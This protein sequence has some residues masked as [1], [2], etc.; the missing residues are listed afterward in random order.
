MQVVLFDNNQRSKLAPLTLTRAVGMIRMGVFTN[1]ERWE[2]ISGNEVHIYTLP[3]LQ[4]LYPKYTGTDA[5][6]IDAAILPTKDFIEQVKELK[7]EEA[8]M[9][10]HQ[11]IIACRSGISYNNF[12]EEELYNVHS[13]KIVMGLKE[14]EYPWQIMQWNKQAIELDIELIKEK[15][16]AK[17]SIPETVTTINRD[18]IFIEEGANVQYAYLNATDGPI[19]IS[20]TATIQEG[21]FIRGPFVLGDNSMVKMGAKIYGATTIGPNCLVGGEIKNIVMTGNSNKAHDGYMGDSVIGEWCNFGAGSS[22]SNIKNTGGTVKVWNQDARDYLPVGQK[23]GLMMG[24]YSKTA[25]N[26]SVNTGSYIGVCCNVFGSGL[27]PKLINN[28]SWGADGKKKY[29]FDK[30]LIEIKNWKEMKHAEISSADIS[31]LKHIFDHF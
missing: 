23:C 2:F 6:W 26:S 14:V 13:T 30:A 15:G 17:F 4:V 18:N 25:I 21:A 3:Y 1:K 20:K 31:V 22:N 7:S 19:Y 27:L 11:R 12:T 10:E 16:I 9:D 28:F 5:I 29:D 24:D 8:L